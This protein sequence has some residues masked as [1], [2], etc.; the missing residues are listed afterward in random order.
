MRSALVAIEVALAL[1]LLLG[2]GLMINTFVRVLHADPG[3][4]SDH[5]L[6]L[7]VRLIGDRYFDISQG[8]KT[9]LSLVTLQVG[10]FCRQLLP[11]IRR[12]PGVES[13]A[14]IDWLPMLKDQARPTQGF[15]MAGRPSIGS[16]EQPAALFSAVSSDYFR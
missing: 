4:K 12:L 10:I 6:T 14:L 2:A 1:V 11:R 5:L 3:F 8:E 16:G 9:G 15:T 7:E 13:A